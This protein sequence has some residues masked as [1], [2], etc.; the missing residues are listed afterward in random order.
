MLLYETLSQPLIFLIIFCI[1]LGSGII[2]DLKSYM[3]FLCEKNKIMSIILDIISA[4][5][6]CGILFLSNLI[7]NYGEFRF[8]IL[9]AFT[10][11]FLIERFTLGIFV[12]KFFSWLYFSSK[13]LIRKIFKKIEKI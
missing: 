12:K 10:L 6:V 13:N 1:G 5:L 8:Y 3:N 7:F 4:I 11:G 2:F 9:L